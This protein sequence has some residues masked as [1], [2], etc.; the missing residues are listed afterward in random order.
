MI[1]REGGKEVGETR[2][3]RGFR[4]VWRSFLAF[5]GDFD[6]GG[7]GGE[8]EG[9][10]EGMIS[11]TGR[12]IQERMKGEI[13]NQTTEETT[14]L[15]HAEKTHILLQEEPIEDHIEKIAGHLLEKTVV[16][17]QGNNCQ[18]DGVLHQAEEEKTTQTRVVKILGV[19]R[20]L[21]DIIR[22]GR[23]VMSIT[24]LPKIKI[25]MNLTSHKSLNLTNRWKVILEAQM[26][27]TK[28]KLKK[29]I[30]KSQVCLDLVKPLF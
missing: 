9:I 3:R 10:G 18:T 20:D 23:E 16:L 19:Q 7:V 6:L 15:L 8:I 25:T 28:G 12:E 26:C 21:L 29:K 11:M 24:A 5:T 22:G 14:D 2:V 30:L 4:G 1:G 17:L 13:G 27:I